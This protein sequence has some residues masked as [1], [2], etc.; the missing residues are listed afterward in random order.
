MNKKIIIARHVDIIDV[1]CIGL[2]DNDS[3][4]ECSNN[5]EYVITESKFELKY[6]QRGELRRS[7]RGRKLPSTFDKNDVYNINFTLVN[8]CNAD[9]PVNFE[10]TININDLEYWRQAECLSNNNTRKLIGKLE[11]KNILDIKLVYKENV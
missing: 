3:E 2:K 6:E 9:S 4:S 11:S 10:E 7:N 8:L 1:R 5:T